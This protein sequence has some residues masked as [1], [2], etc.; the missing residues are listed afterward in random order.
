M[1]ERDNP[2]GGDRRGLL[3][4]GLFVLALAWRVL[5]LVGFSAL[6]TFRILHIDQRYYSAW[7]RRIA[8]GE[9]LG[10][11]IFEMTPLYAYLLGFVYRFVTTDIFVIK[12]MQS[13][14][15][16]GSVVI[17]F[18]L[19]L[20]LTRSRP[21]ALVAGLLAAAYGP[22]LLYE[23][24]IMKTFL[25]VFF[26]LT[27]LWFLDRSRDPRPALA[28]VLAGVSIGLMALIR[29][30]ALLLVA[31]VPLIFLLDHGLRGGLRLGVLFVLGA[32]LA[33]SPATI[34]NY[35]VGGEFVLITSGGGEVFYMGQNP[36][37]D[38]T[39]RP[40]SFVK[41]NN[42]FQE[43]EE[44]R[45]E[46]R[47]R[48]GKDLNREES[49]R[50]WFRQGLEWMRDHP[51][52]YLRLQWHKFVLFWNHYEFPDNLNYYFMKERV[53]VLG[54]APGFGL[55]APFGIVGLLLSLRRPR[56]YAALHLFIAAYMV[57]VLLFY[58]FSRFRLPLVPL[59]LLF[60]GGYLAWLCH[61]VFRGTARERLSGLTSLPL[62]VLAFLFVNQ[63]AAGLDP[64]SAF[65]EVEHEKLALSYVQT[66]EYAEARREFERVL[67]VR[68]SDTALLLNL[69][70]LDIRDD[71]EERA[72][73]RMGRALAAERGDAIRVQLQLAGQIGDKEVKQ[74]FQ[75]AFSAAMRRLKRE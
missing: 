7:A 45:K 29:E 63:D 18:L 21:A 8:D 27:A 13:V 60:A 58:N 12:V 35:A 73:A 19:T 34:R 65:Y 31:C 54:V 50:Y 32:L 59:L 71:Q 26:S 11:D 64:R 57:S 70:L 20:R 16:S 67:E 15:G 68:P 36:E 2:P 30:N 53:G 46:A 62:L 43:H 69:A 72:L 41:V 44:F 39:Y 10:H 14:V 4:L 56:R 33:I 66:G 49:S 61:S 1:E 28:A 38:G 24:M 42:P 47:R 6:P 22:F 9:L 3:A 75:S 25:A 52:D 55:L 5:F 37:A 40:P 48:T 51:G 23:G 17:L 74:R